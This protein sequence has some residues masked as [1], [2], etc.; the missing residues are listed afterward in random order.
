MQG[1]IGHVGLGE[2]NALEN[3]AI[4]RGCTGNKNSVEQSL[5]APDLYVSD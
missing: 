1:S 5:E 4:P 3:M 2:P